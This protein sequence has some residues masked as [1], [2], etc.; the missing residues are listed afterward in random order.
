M[1][2]R[3]MLAS[4]SKIRPGKSRVGPRPVESQASGMTLPDAVRPFLEWAQEDLLTCRQMAILMTVRANPG[5]STGA[6][7]EVLGLNKPAV[8]RTADKLVALGMLR[9]MKEPNDLRMVRLVPVTSK[10]GR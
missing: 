9:R 5:V 4:G 10:K 7:A 2:M 1:E 6:I 8:T 3:K